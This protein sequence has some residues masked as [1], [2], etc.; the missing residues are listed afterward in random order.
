MDDTRTPVDDL[1]QTGELFSPINTSESPF[2]ISGGG[3]RGRF[4]LQVS[5]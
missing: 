3:R 2:P 1:F 5:Q 4:E